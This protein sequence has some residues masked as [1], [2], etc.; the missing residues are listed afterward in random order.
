VSDRG[1]KKKRRSR[2]AKVPQLRGTELVKDPKLRRF[3]F[4][5]CSDE[6]LHV[7]IGTFDAWRNQDSTTHVE[8]SLSDYWRTF[9]TIAVTRMAETQAN[10]P[11]VEDMTLEELEGFGFLLASHKNVVDLTEG[12]SFS[13][14]I[15][16]QYRL[17]FYN[18][19][20]WKS[21]ASSTGEEFFSSLVKCYQHGKRYVFELIIE[22]DYLDPKPEGD[23]SRSGRD[24]STWGELLARIDV[25]SKQ[26]MLPNS[27]NLM[28]T[29]ELASSLTAKAA[30][31]M[32][33][34]ASKTLLEQAKHA[35]GTGLLNTMKHLR[36]AEAHL[37]VSN[38]KELEPVNSSLRMALAGMHSPRRLGLVDTM[39]REHLEQYNRLMHRLDPTG[40]LRNL[41]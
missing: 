24:I 22:D 4:N 41:K 5:R 40:V 34:P 6:Q 36:N 33:R 38:T 3:N 35:E 1:K 37:M 19:V 12:K 11:V 26:L 28:S 21:V 39:A 18:K 31:T 7:L 23:T 15:D 17:L 27:D 16:N 32:L 9:S 14:S 8:A 25:L 2:K 30:S 29:T 10:P 20:G 13:A